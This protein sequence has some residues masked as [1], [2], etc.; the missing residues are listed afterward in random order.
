MRL[1]RGNWLAA[2]ALV[3]CLAGSVFADDIKISPASLPN[4]TVGVAYSQHLQASGCSKGCAWSSAGTLPPG[5]SLGTGSGV[6]SGTPTT[7]GSFPFGVTATAPDGSSASQAYTVTI[8]GVLTITTPS[9]LPGGRVG[10]AY[11]EAFAVSGGT[12]PYTWSV[13]GG[14]LPAGLSLDPGGTLAGTPTAANVFS[15]TLRAVDQNNLSASKAFT[16]AVAASTPPSLTITTASPLPAGTAGTPYSQT[17]SA[18]GGTPPYSWTVVQGALPSGILLDPGGTLAGTPTAANVFSFTLR[19]VDQNNLSASKA[20]TLTV[21]A[22]TPS[23]TITTTSPLP[24]GT[25]GSPYSQ[26]LSASG[27]TPPYSWT[28]IQ[29]A[30]PS[31]LSLNGASGGLSGTPSAANT[32]QFTIQ[33]TDTAGA[34]ATQALTLVIAPSVSKLTITTTSPLPDGRVGTAYTEAFAASGGTAPYTWSVSEGALPA[35]LS[36]D[37]GGTLGGTPTAANVFS[38]TLRA[39]DQ[40]NLSASKAFTLTVAA[41]TPSLTVTTTSPL[42]AG[43]AGSPYS[44]TLSASGG[45][46]PYHWTVIQGAL[47]GGILLD[48]SSGALAGTPS[49][50][51]TFQFTIQATDTAGAKAS[52]ALTLVIGPSVSK[53]T[54]TTTSP[55]PDGVAGTRYSQVLTAAG[56]SP[57]YLWAVTSGALPDGLGLDSGG[58]ISGTP[59][60]A[61]RFPFTVRVTD[62]SSATADVGLQITIG[63]AAAAPALSFSGVPSTAGSGQQ[64]AFNVVLS[65]A[66]SQQVSGQVSLSFQPDAAATTDDPAIQFASGSRTVSFTIPANATTAVFDVRPMALQTGTVAGTL[67]L[68]VSSNLPGGN[69]SQAIVVARSAPIV[70]SVKVVTGSSGFEV[71]VAGYSNTRE[72]SGASFHFA[73]QSGQTVQT[74]DLNVSLAMPASEWYTGTASNQFGGQFLLVVPF[75][76]SQG[77]L[78]GLSSVGVQLQNGQGTSAMSNANF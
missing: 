67:K 13:S 62:S 32:F 66:F 42:P 15:F 48:G 76:V 40:N 58:T 33:A 11:S 35:G 77:G 55:L 56:G 57:P 68:A 50:A 53:L 31:G 1:H 26:T 72:L 9:P 73:A 47:P 65:S 28:V 2:G 27:G 21:A 61:G 51:N 39:V 20:F 49:A 44:Q 22:S 46:P 75:T 8:N 6:I 36:L 34:K 17:L 3:G 29:G 18:S 74:S 60:T 43:T 54:I 23:L 24:A 25:A 59:G 37:P 63:P 12:G 45:T 78:T 16:L 64:I 38:F 30:L 41:S 70:Q 14:A 7:A 4:G 5:L 71:Q 52:K 69:M 19:A 10:A